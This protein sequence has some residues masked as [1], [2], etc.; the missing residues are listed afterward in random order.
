MAGSF[1]RS[2]KRIADLRAVMN[3]T[4]CGIYGN[5]LVRSGLRRTR[6][7]TVFRAPVGR[8]GG[9]LT[10]MPELLALAVSFHQVVHPVWPSCE[11]SAILARTDERPQEC[12]AH[13]A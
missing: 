5:L 8:S 10:S 3:I 7:S 6:K 1:D 2:E 13:A 9:S 11:A 4:L 12:P